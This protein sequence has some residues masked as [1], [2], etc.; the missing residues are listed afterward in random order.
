MST[1]KTDTITTVDGTG[2]ITFSRP[3]TGNGGLGKILAVTQSVKT[4]TAS[5]TSTSA[6]AT[7]LAVTTGTLSSGS[8]VL[9]Q[10]SVHSGNSTTEQRTHFTL[11]ND[12]TQLFLGDSGTGHQVS[13]WF[14]SMDAYS[15]YNISFMFLH[16]PSSTSAQ[17]YT[18]K[19]HI[20]GSQTA[21]I[22]RANGEDSNSGRTAS[23]IT[24]MEVGA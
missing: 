13:S 19:Y 5:T 1:L 8:K 4:D 23:S 7:G 15:I 14:R 24:A 21:W 20:A 11:W 12:T 16:D 18:L 3:V 17:T 22:N 9:V 6:V 10:V 2:N